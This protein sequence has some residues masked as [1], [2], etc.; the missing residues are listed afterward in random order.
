MANNLT[1]SQ[2]AEVLARKTLRSGSFSDN[3]SFYQQ[4]LQDGQL[5]LGSTSDDDKIILYKDEFLSLQGVDET[6]YNNLLNSPQLFLTASYQEGYYHNPGG[7]I[8]ELETRNLVSEPSNVSQYMTF[9]RESITIDPEKL[10]EVLDTD[11]FEL[12]PEQLNR[13]DQVNNFF[14][15]YFELRPGN[16]PPFCI[17]SETGVYTVDLGPLT[18]GQTPCG[19]STTYDLW[20]QEND[21]SFPDGEIQDDSIT[22]LN[23]EANED[24]TLEGGVYQT[25]Q[26]IHQDLT[27]YLSDIL[28][29]PPDDVQDDR[30][31]YEF[32]SDGYL[33][34]RNLN[35]SIIIKKGEGPNIGVNKTKQLFA[36]DG[37]TSIWSNLYGP[38]SFV[39]GIEVPYYLMDGFTITMWVKFLDKVNGG[40]LFN[41]GNPTREW[42]PHGFKLET[43]V[44]NQDD[45]SE[46]Q[47]LGPGYFNDNNYERFIRLV[48]REKD[49]SLRDSHVGS[50]VDSR[51]NTKN[52]Q[53]QI[54]EDWSQ[55]GNPP[56]FSYTRVPINFDEWYFVVA[57]YNPL[58]C[59][60]SAFDGTPTNFNGDSCVDSQTGYENNE[61]FWLNHIDPTNGDVSIHKSGYGAK[62]KV[63]IISRSDLIRARGYKPIV[64]EE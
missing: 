57:S 23:S 61:N 49:G 47:G 40:T 4:V 63:E 3:L 42:S 37:D 2:I 25:L 53:G 54:Y 29:Q 20:K 26:W 39:D 16:K 31:E 8:S 59:E 22:R 28:N 5:T 24:N 38:D 27:E 10:N 64:E 46:Y 15:A 43:Y 45:Y 14:N 13:Q 18:D 30:P 6:D 1:R 32:Q 9:D 7:L 62:C 48:V 12:L 56:P 19:N 58:I 33:Q 36:Q 51:V 55:D 41:F 44:V 34:I 52:I 21:I 17:D 50:I 60:D 35:Q 11:V